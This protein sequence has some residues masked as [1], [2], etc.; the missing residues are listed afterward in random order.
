[1][2]RSKRRTQKHWCPDCQGQPFVPGPP[3]IR[4]GKSHETVMRCPNIKPAREADAQL[5]LGLDTQQRRAGER[6]E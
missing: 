3:V 2:T 1:M 5:P 4:N 6:D